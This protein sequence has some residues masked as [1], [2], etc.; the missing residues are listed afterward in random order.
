MIEGGYYIKAR[1]I[2][3]SNISTAPP[4]IRE[5]WDWLLMEANHT[6]KKYAGFNVK[7][8]Q[9]FRT[10]NAIREGLSWQIGWRKM[11]YNENQTKKAMK[12]LRE[13][14]MIDTTKEPGGV[15]VTICK[16][17]HYQDP[18]NY[19]RTTKD[20]MERTIEEPLKNHTLPY[21]NKNDKNIIN[22]LFVEFWNLYD[23]KVG[24]KTKCEKKWK[25]LSDEQ[26]SKII[27]GLPAWKK[28]IIDKQYQ[29]HPLTYLNNDRWE[30]E[31]QSLEKKEDFSGRTFA[32]GET[33]KLFTE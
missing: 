19:E 22:I 28:T 1:C 5:I 13:A 15:L 11:M 30:D 12:F 25:S 3:M 2:Q 10:Y 17:D 7:R 29:P 4:Y 16:Y 8:G 18:K 27:A 20:P 23:K 26:R 24:S 33:D 21:N 32:V 6:D 31:I 14:G 9:L